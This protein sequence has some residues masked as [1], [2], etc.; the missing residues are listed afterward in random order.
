MTFREWAK[1]WLERRGM[2]GD[3]ADTVVATITSQKDSMSDRWD[4]QAETYPPPIKRVI[5]IALTRHA[6]DYI[7]ENCP[8]AWF[9]AMFEPST[10]DK[11]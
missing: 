8:E 9:R 10:E 3:Q 2:F 6:L 11:P 4:D 1:D 7:K 5:A